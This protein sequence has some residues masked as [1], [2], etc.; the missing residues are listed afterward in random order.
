MDLQ[1]LF[2]ERLLSLLDEKNIS[3]GELAEKVGCSRQ[4]IN[5]YTMGKRCPDIVLAGKM[6]RVLGVSCDY[7]IGI[8]DYK[9]GDEAVM[10]VK[11]AGLAPDTMKFFV[12]LKE[13]SEELERE[14]MDGY[15]KQIAASARE[16]A[17]QTLRLLNALISHD[18]FGPLLQVVRRF[19][20]ACNGDEEMLQKLNLEL[21]SPYTGNVYGGVLEKL[22]M[23]KEFYLYTA[24]KYFNAIVEDIVK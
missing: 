15:E 14:Y 17:K 3:Q 12:G 9:N 19:Q 2:G 21:T 7:L 1:Q 5:F 11:D 23:T 6:A 4:S 10:S 22:D 18:A 20:R 16:G 8:S 13:F 24:A